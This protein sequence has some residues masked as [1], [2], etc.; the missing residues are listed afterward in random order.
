MQMLVLGWLQFHAAPQCL[1]KNGPQSPLPDEE[2]HLNSSPTI[3]QP[4]GEVAGREVD[5][6][7]PDRP[8]G[9]EAERA[10]KE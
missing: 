1:R 10:A 8:A 7:W 2:S 6:I 3:A 5:P 4:D 9:N